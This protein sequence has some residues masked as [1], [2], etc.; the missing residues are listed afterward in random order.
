MVLTLLLAA[1]VEPVAGRHVATARSQA[2]ADR[3]RTVLLARAASAGRVLRPPLRRRRRVPHA[4][5]PTHR[6]AALDAAGHQSGQ[7]HVDRV[8]RPGHV[9]VLGAVDG[10]RRRAVAGEP[11][12]A[13]AGRSPSHRRQPPL[14]TRS[15]QG[16]G[17]LFQRRAD[18]RDVEGRRDRVR[19]LRPLGRLPGQGGPRRTGP[20]HLDELSERRAAAAH[21]PDHGRDLDHR[22][23]AGD[24]RQP[25][26]RGAGR[27]PVP[28]CELQ[29]P[30]RRS[31][32]LGW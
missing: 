9:A 28:D 2:R 27:V 12:G 25:Q 23:T 18:D 4:A 11:R 22:R 3:L 21:R 8:L 5:Q 14:R 6:P 17:H 32:H 20:R 26:H 19:L 15:R 13:A 29:R 24:R 10:D 1:D 7:S 30:R 16:H 31:R